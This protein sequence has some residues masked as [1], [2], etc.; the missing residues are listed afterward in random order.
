M[1]LARQQH[2]E[3]VQYAMRR[4]EVQRRELGRLKYD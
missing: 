2:E 4:N 1:I 3:L